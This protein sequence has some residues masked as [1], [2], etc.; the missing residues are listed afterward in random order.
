[1]GQQYAELF[2]RRI[3]TMVIDSNMDHSLPTTWQFLQTEATA[4]QESFD[5]FVAWCD[6]TS[7][8]ALHGRDVRR[9]FADLYARAERGELTVPGTDANLDQ[10][11]LLSLASSMFYGP[12]W[13]ILAGILIELE[14][15]QPNPALDQR[16][17][18]LLAAG[19]AGPDTA[20][21]CGIRSR[22]CSA[23]TGAFRY[24]TSSNW[25]PIGWRSPTSR[26]T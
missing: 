21:P 8:C 7:A 12:N 5:Q 25:R 14:T 1:M 17:S 16:V 13:Q 2:P 19:R 22:R 24:T 6:R 15:G 26:R 4:A 23:R 10:M 11:S 18:A 9:V 20:R 3:R